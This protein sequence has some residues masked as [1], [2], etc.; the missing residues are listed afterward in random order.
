MEGERFMGQTI[1]GWGHLGEDDDFSFIHGSL[2]YLWVT[3]WGCTAGI[4]YIGLD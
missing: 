4:G 3:N 1:Q 2:K